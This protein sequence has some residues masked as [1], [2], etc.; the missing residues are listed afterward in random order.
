MDI[1]LDGF[2]TRVVFRTARGYFAALAVFGLLAFVVGGLFG[3]S[4]VLR[5]TPPE[6]MAPELPAPIPEPEPVE[7]AAVKAFVERPDPAPESEVHYEEVDEGFDLPEPSEEDAVL[8]AEQEKLLLRQNL[9]PS[10]RRSFQSLNTRGRRPTR[11]SVSETVH[12]GAYVRSDNVTKTA[13]LKSSTP[14]SR[15]KWSSRS[16][17]R[18]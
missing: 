13:S 10:S 3:A 2:E 15:L 12:T 8:S 5:T 17:I 14:I 9:N 18:S 11:W 6:P 4:G 1:N 16:M 7:L